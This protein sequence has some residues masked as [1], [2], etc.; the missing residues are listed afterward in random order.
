MRNRWGVWLA[1]LVL[2]LAGCSSFSPGDADP[3]PGQDSDEQPAPTAAP[4]ADD[5][6]DGAEETT[7]STR[8]GIELA[9]SHTCA[10]A[11][12]E[13]VLVNGEYVTVIPSQFVRAGIEDAAAVADDQGNESIDLRFDDD[14]TAIVESSSAQVAEAG[15][16]GRLVMKVGDQMVSALAVPTALET[17]EVRIALPPDTSA[18]TVVEL[19][20]AG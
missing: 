9:V 20:R 4:S 16:D 7:S 13:C 19:I 5:G 2:T 15:Q 10:P 8:G 12:P 11:E 18:D 1:A 3:A 14:G 17:S 6:R